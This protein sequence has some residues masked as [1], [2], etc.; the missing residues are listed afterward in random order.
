M[1]LQFRQ[2][3]KTVINLGDDVSVNSLLEDWPLWQSRIIS[4]SQLEKSNRLKVKQLL[5]SLDESSS[6]TQ[7]IDE[8]IFI[9]YTNL[10]Y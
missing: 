5:A 8:G 2:E 9:V 1:L 4:Y 3:F 6:D 7:H 10:K